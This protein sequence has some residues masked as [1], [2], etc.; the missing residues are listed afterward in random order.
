MTRTESAARHPPRSQGSVCKIVKETI[1][2][3]E[4]K[5]MEK[6]E[7]KFVTEIKEHNK[8]KETYTEIDKAIIYKE[9][10]DDL[11]RAKI[12]HGTCVRKIK[13][14]PNYD[15]TN[16]IVIWYDNDLKRTYTVEV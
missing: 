15:G 9:L 3:R 5:K 10:A 4:M 1:K 14:S 6:R 7:I 11:I 16:T 2:H 13:R 8:W 12:T